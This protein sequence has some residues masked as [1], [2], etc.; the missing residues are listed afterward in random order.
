[1]IPAISFFASLFH[2][3]PTPPLPSFLLSHLKTY[4]ALFSTH[5]YHTRTNTQKVKNALTIPGSGKRAH[6]ACAPRLT[7]VP[8]LDTK[9]RRAGSYS[10]KQESRRKQEVASSTA[11]HGL[12]PCARSTDLPEL[13]YGLNQG[14]CSGGGCCGC[15]CG[16]CGCCCGGG[17]GWQEG[18]KWESRGG[19]GVPRC[20]SIVTMRSAARH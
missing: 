8:S 18:E 19:V 2:S 12:L 5:T 14:C 1:M 16:C 15:C 6:G 11:A 10:T 20:P 7:P 13:Q 4:T 9:Q 17:C 3:P